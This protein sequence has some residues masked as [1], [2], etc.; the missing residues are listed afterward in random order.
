MSDQI[1]AVIY[2]ARHEIISFVK[3]WFNTA[4]LI[5]KPVRQYGIV[6]P[7]KICHILQTFFTCA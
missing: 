5:V 7:W 3:Y 6:K 1:R 2:L 4:D